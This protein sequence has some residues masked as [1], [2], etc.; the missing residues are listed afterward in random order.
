MIVEE[1]Q[2]VK[3]KQELLRKLD[4]SYDNPIEQEKDELR[5]GEL[6]RLI[7]QELLEKMKDI[8]IE[9]TK[10]SEELKIVTVKDARTLRK[11]K[12]EVYKHMAKQCLELY[13]QLVE[14]KREGAELE[15]KLQNKNLKKYDLNKTISEVRRY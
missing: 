5:L 13:H 12:R 2:L 9:T 8:K 15:E 4:K 6:N 11:Q 10:K 1:S 3:E 14:K 7:K